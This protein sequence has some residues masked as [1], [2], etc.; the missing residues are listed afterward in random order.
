ML[1]ESQNKVDNMPKIA[2][3]NSAKCI[4]YQIRFAIIRKTAE[5]LCK[6]GTKFAQFSFN[7]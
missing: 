6:K 3:V 7:S 2:L 1:R 4:F 5:K